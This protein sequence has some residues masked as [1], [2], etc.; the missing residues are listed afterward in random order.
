M[1]PGT[2]PGVFVSALRAEGVP[3]T[4]GYVPLYKERLFNR[5][6]AGA[7]GPVL[8]YSG[9]H[10]PVCELVCQDDI[11]FQQRMLLGE[12]ADMDDIA[13][14]ITKIQSAWT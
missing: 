1:T 8:D 9:V 7:D 11:W 5:K 6:M 12:K 2:S 3:C 10:C 14:A 13:A 4:S